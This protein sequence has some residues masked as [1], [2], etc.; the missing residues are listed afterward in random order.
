MGSS[1]RRDSCHRTTKWMPI[2]WRNVVQTYHIWH[3]SW[4]DSSVNDTSDPNQLRRNGYF[5]QAFST[6]T[7]ADTAPR[8]PDAT[9]ITT[10]PK[11]GHN[12]LPPYLHYNSVKVHP[13]LLLKESVRKH[14]HK[15]LKEYMIMCSTRVLTAT[16]VH[17]G[18]L[19]WPSTWAQPPQRKGRLPQFS[20]E[21]YLSFNRNAISWKHWV[22]FEDLQIW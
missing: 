14:F 9:V 2:C 21:N 8:T 10:P 7:V 18:N 17:W 15:I 1:S 13:D 5:C 16:T 4:K 19:K 22:F 12:Q 11:R 6:T 20:R 3:C